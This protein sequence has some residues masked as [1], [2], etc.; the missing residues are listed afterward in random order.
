MEMYSVSNQEI[1]K[2]FPY[3]EFRK[4]QDKIVLAINQGLNSGVKCVL[5][6]APTG[7]GK[8]GIN[9]TFA[10]TKPSFY[11][12]PQNQLITQILSD[13]YLAPYFMEIKGRQNYSCIK[14]YTGG[15]TVDLGMCT[16]YKNYIPTYCKH[17]SECPYWTQK[18][19]VIN[20]VKERIGIT[21][22]TYLILEGKLSEPNPPFLGNREMLIVDEGH[23]IDESIVN[24]ISIE[25]KPWEIGIQ[26]PR[27]DNRQQLTGYLQLVYDHIENDL[28]NIDGQ[29]DVYGEISVFD[30]KRKNTL[31][32]VKNQIEQYLESYEREEWLWETR[33]STITT[34]F[35]GIPKKR[36]V[37]YLKVTPLSAKFFG[38]FLWRKSSEIIFISSATLLNPHGLIRET[39]LDRRFKGD[40]IL[41][42]QSPSIFPK[43]N[44]PILD[45]T[46]GSMIYKEQD[47][48]L[49]AA[50]RK[51]N[52]ILDYEKGNV[53]VHIPS[54]ELVDKIMDTIRKMGG[55]QIRHWSR[56][57][58]HESSDRNEKLESWVSQ[59]GFVFFA[60]AF[61]EGHDWKGD[62]CDAQ[63]LFKVPFP[64]IK[65]KRVA[66]MLALKRWDWYY[67]R[68]FITIIQ[69]YGRSIR[70]E[71]DR[72]PFYILDSKFWDLIKYPKVKQ[73]IPEWFEEVIPKHR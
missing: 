9:T 3:P 23:S 18:L 49:E 26:T 34:N 57:I 53:V 31:A 62:I 37:P 29:K 46:V 35:E 65:D 32:N 25:V 2:L 73:I 16:R 47:R 5:L 17:T 50:C 41:I 67:T 43:E 61:T 7:L 28:K 30:V 69:A 60:V 12:T 8:S 15:S 4:G 55:E 39:G 27:I 68:T 36:T 6:S 45:M 51:V 66:R 21:N 44:R 10:R 72:K 48:N 40:E 71:T 24:L 42:L 33:F 56:F 54:Y 52:E 63:I 59:R 14:D 1:L 20:S 19:A 58:T 38:Y 64:N 70:S 22:P 11:T 13:V